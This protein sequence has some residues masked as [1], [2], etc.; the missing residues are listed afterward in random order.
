MNMAKHHVSTLA[1]QLRQKI[2][3]ERI[4]QEAL[5]SKIGISAAQVSRLLR[6]KASFAQA[7]DELLRAIA[8]YLGIPVV[9]CFVLAGRLLHRDFF[10]PEQA[11]MQLAMDELVRSPAADSLNVERDELDA[12][13]EKLQLLLWRMH[14]QLSRHPLKG[15][16]HSWLHRW[17]FGSSR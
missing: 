16:H 11:P 6:G 3:Y 8:D 9:Q 5:A 17:L 12:L 1:V 10:E 14:L 2:N 7:D 13:P 15:R 4:S